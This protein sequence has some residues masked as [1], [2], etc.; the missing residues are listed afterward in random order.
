MT[1]EKAV[2]EG[3]Q[4]V[5]AALSEFLSG[6]VTINDDAY[7]DSPLVASPFLNILN[8]D[9][10]TSRND[11]QTATGVYDIPVILY[12]D[13]VDWKTSLN[14]F[15][16]TRQAII[17]TFTAVGTARS[18]GGLDG[19][20]INEIRGDGPITGVSY[21]DEGRTLPVYLMQSIIFHVELY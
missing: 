19:V 20:D 12:Q 7:L 21:D 18:A 9:S 8:A 14:A 16:D 6:D 3:I 10:F 5:V 17:T 4:T 11:T 13:F 15:R 1:T 2:Q